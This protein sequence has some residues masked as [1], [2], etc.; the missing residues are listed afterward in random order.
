MRVQRQYHIADSY[1]NYTNTVKQKK[2]A[3]EQITQNEFITKAVA[4]AARVTIQTIAVA[5]DPRQ[6]ST[7]FKMSGSIL[8]QPKLKWKIEGKYDGL[9][10]YKLEVSNV[11]Q[12]YNLSQT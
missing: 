3:S 1:T 11:L 5:S 9:P 12:N 2:M 7:G 4:E 10:N 6:D 8:K